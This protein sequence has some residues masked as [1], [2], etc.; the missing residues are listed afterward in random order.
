M[1]KLKL[2]FPSPHPGTHLLVETRI[3]EF[4]LWL[5][6]LPS[7]NM[8]RYVVEVADAISHINR[9]E[10][11]IAHRMSLIQLVDVA[12]EKIHDFYRPL[13]KT[14]PHKG[15]HAPQKELKQVYRL[16]REMSFA[17]KIAVYAYFDKKTFFGKNKN[18]ANVINM[19]LHYLGLVLLEHYELYSPIPMHIWLEI[20]QLYF[21]AEQRDLS[22]LENSSIG[23]K[24]CFNVAETTYIRV[25]LI[26]LSNPYH[27]K[28]GD[29]WEIFTYLSHWTEQVIISEDP[30]DFSRRNCFVIDLD[31]DD[32][33]QSMKQLTDNT[34][35]H[36]RFLLTKQLSIKLCHTIDEIQA[37]NK[38][39]KK[40]FSRNVVARKANQ[41]L[42]EMLNSWETKQER[43]SARYPKVN[44]M[45][46]IW[47]LTNIHLVV[48][49][50]DPLQA[51]KS[52][53]ELEEIAQLVELHWTAVNSSDGGICIFQPDEK[54]R[55][56]DVG[57]LV[58]IRETIS[59]ESAT[60]WRLGIISWITGNKRN[61]T[62]IGIQYLKG[63]IQAVQLQARKG[64]KIDTRYQTALLL[65]GEKVQGLSTPTLLTT[66]GLYVES[67]PMLLRIGEE[68]QFIHAR[69]KISSSGSIDR[70]FYQVADQHLR[71]DEKPTKSKSKQTEA[72]K[73]A[74]QT[75]E[76][77]EAEE[78]I[79]LSAMPTAHIEDFDAEAKK[80]KDQVV[81][82]DD[83]I[84]SKNK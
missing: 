69:M 55:N 13:M 54:I 4:S 14:G 49:A 81:T 78:V 29:H 3:D 70:F 28:R 41:L 58:A 66:S 34:N 72:A 61:G 26:A 60:N 10:L 8:P 65:S 11:S 44:K 68:E 18:L 16:T 48:S 51:N 39:P 84:V 67:R 43:Q 50:S 42:E 46:V 52:E 76:T 75:D 2:T 20:H 9:T 63:E 47:G 56:V 6:E 73:K 33:P 24:N 82:L 35:P 83:M 77:E 1:D 22:E 23:L 25:C 62:K 71:E 38:S 79:D 12:Y 30:D 53:S 45:E 5:E 21:Y 15:K 19:A 57:L 80:A 64:N 36:F 27:L 40:C 37:S 32:K 74:E 7:G 17:Y 59:N 31:D